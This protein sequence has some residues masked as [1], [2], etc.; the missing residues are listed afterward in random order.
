MLKQGGCDASR[1]PVAEE[2]TQRRGVA[3]A[4]REV[5]RAVREVARAVREVT[6]RR[7]GGHSTWHPDVIPAGTPGQVAAGELELWIAQV[8]ESDDSRY[9]RRKSS[10]QEAFV[11]IRITATISS[12]VRRS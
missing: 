10:I 7:R 8:I 5:A 9:L 6:Q 1:R 3:R 4:V 2:P 12:R 11:Y